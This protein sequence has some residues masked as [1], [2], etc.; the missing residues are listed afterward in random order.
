MPLR[1]YDIIMFSRKLLSVNHNDWCYVLIDRKYIKVFPW[2]TTQSFSLDAVHNKLG[3]DTKP[4]CRYVG[5]FGNNKNQYK[6]IKRALT[7]SFSLIQGPP[8]TVVIW[9]LL[10]FYA[11]IRHD[12]KIQ[13]WGYLR[14]DLSVFT[15]LLYFLVREQTCVLKT[16]ITNW[17]KFRILSYVGFTYHYF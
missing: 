8:G 9:I 4:D 6:A 16:I 13:S 14:S 12:I 17:F 1:S 11:N 5:L 15:A 7:T 10:D 2:L 3:I